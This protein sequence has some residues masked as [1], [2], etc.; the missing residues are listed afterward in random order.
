MST[1]SEPAFPSV[2]EDGDI[3]QLR[4]MLSRRERASLIGGSGH[5][6]IELPETVQSL[7]LQIL[8]EMERGNAVTIVPVSEELSTQQAAEMIGVSRPF[9]VKLLESGKLPFHLAGSHRRVYLRDLLEFKTARDR[10]RLAS[11][12]RVGDAMEEADVYDKVLLPG[13]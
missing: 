2:A 8:E 5:R 4:S 7:L 11:L 9:F 10:E 3:R 6:A 13:E 1:V 12:D